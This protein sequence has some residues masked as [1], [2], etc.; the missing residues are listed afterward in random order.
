[1]YT[2]GGLVHDEVLWI[3]HGVGDQRIAVASVPLVDVLD[4]MA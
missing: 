2:C 3:P 1:V 4:A